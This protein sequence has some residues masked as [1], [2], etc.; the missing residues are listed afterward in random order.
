MKNKIVFFLLF[1]LF[2]SNLF[3]DNWLLLFSWEDL[4]E[5][6][7]GFA[8]FRVVDDAIKENLKR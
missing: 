3:A 6:E 7:E 8:F 1:L 2:K 5:S 4:L